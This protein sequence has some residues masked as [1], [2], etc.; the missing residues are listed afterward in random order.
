MN[1][2]RGVRKRVFG[3]GGLRADRQGYLVIEVAGV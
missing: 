2:A 1:L 3:L